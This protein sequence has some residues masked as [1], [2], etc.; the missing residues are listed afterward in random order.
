MTAAGK[1]VVL[2]GPAG[3]GKTTLAHRVI[4]EQPASRG[5][6]VS[7]TTRPIR[8]TERDGVDYHFVDRAAF[9]QLRDAGGFAEWAEVH[10]NLYGTSHAEIQRLT[11]AGRTVFF[12]V[13]IVG[14]HNL[15]RQ[16]PQQTRLVFVLPP[17][18]AQLVARL[19]ARGTETDQTLRRRLQTAR[20]ELQAL[21]ASTAPWWLVVND[22]LAR[23]TAA[24][25]AIAA[26][27]PPPPSVPQDDA[28]LATLLRDATADPRTDG[29]R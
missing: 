11:G 24:L 12:D 21:R 17:S 9:E 15:W 20:H 25:A 28:L 16:Y 13:D 5:F 4:D 7:H 6:S 2:V 1:L 19:Q 29:S 3:A 27:V 26:Q 22:D 10:G 23:A 18:W 8:A 14:A